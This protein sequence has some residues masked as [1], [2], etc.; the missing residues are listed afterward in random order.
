M[1]GKLVNKKAFTFLELVIVMAIVG[2]L[3]SIAIPNFMSRRPVY[4]RKQFVD[5][6]NAL[7]QVAWQDT[8]V[9]GKLH[10]ITFDISK[11]AVTAEVQT[12]K[13][14]A[15][16]EYVFTSM[17]SRYLNATYQWP[18][19]T[20]EFKNFYVNKRD[21]L[22]LTLSDKKGKIWFFIVPDG[23][24]QP[25]IINMVE[26]AQNGLEFALVLNPF[27]VQFKEYDT[28]QRP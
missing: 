23:L 22:N 6:L 25:V 5:H 9:T 18:E 1:F 2:I 28:L 16:D 7:L 27:S 13:K 15:T 24:A 20:F 17:T 21:E 8:V 14:T 10:R 11:R 19:N 26:T 3:L 4:A 12:N